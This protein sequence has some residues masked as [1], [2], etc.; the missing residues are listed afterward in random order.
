MAPSDL[1]P[2]MALDEKLSRTRSYDSYEEL[3]GYELAGKLNFSFV[4]TIGN[5]LAGFV[6]AHPTFLYI[7]ITEVCI[8][9][10]IVVDPDYRRHHIGSRLI[11]ELVIKCK[12]ENI[13]IIRALVKEPD[14]S[15]RIFIEQ[16]GF[17][18][19]DIVNY[20]RVHEG[21]IEE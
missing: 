4:A 19:S 9:N 6:I 17:Q 8:I 16:L 12:A 7:P 1:G 15:L 13:S 21:A 20:D 18:K 11:E 14:E 5:R 3:F 10:S 2:V